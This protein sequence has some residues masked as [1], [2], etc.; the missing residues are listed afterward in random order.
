MSSLRDKVAV[1]TGSASGIGEATVRTMAERGAS[2]VV[3]D[4]DGDGARR[5]ASEVAGEGGTAIAVT[6]DVSQPADVEAMIDAARS[7][8]GR[9]DVLHNN[10]VGGSPLDADVV[11]MDLA[12]WDAA[13]AVNLRGYLLGCKA[14][15]PHMLE[16]GS[17]VII[18]TSSN[19][20]LAGD[21]TRT[22][23]GVSKAGINALTMYVATQYGR[24]GIRCNAISPGL[25]MTPK[26]AS[27]EALPADI[28]E[29]YQRSHLTPRFAYP[30]DIAG[31]A[32]FLASDEAEM[33][34]GQV[35]CM[36]GGMLAHTPGY[37]HFLEA[38]GSA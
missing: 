5:V 18:N 14:V 35:L 33:I 6:V 2:V 4:I 17:G 24:F 27:E 30:G 12:A 13:M 21:L 25:V 32:A 20:A 1:V 3:A 7:A 36:D 15:L 10:A 11:N 23:Y 31:Y 16:R 19:S 26:M 29:I 8:Y 38:F 34:N 9:V 28:R 22:A 37:A